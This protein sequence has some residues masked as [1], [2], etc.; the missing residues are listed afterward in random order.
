MVVLVIALALFF[1]FTN[2]FHDT[3]N[4]MATPI[5]TGAIKP[6]TA[7]ALA[8]ILNLVGAF[9]STEVAKTISGGIIN[10]GGPNGVAITPEMIFA[11]LMGAVL[12]NLLTWLLG[13]PSSSS[14]ALFGG[15]IGAAIVGTW[16]L[17]AVN[18]M[19]VV[20]KV[21]LPA[22]LAP[23]IAG[24]VA[25]LCTK[26]AYGITRRSDPDSGDKLTQ[27]R[28]GF[29]RGQVFSSSLVA[30][31]HGTNDAQKTMGVI[32]LVL[33]ASGLQTAGTGPHIWV[34][35][36]CALAIAGGTYAG[37]WRIIRTLGSGLTDV[38]PAQGFAA[39]TSTAAAILAS[40]HLGFALSTT[41]VASG[42]VIGSGLGRK[43]STVRW[44]AIGKIGV[45]WLLT[46][47]SAAIVGGLA[48]LLIRTGT[49]GIVIVA[50]LGLGAILYMFYMSQREVVDHNNA[51]SDVD[52]VGEA[53][54]IPS[55]KEREKLAAKARA[56]QKVADK[57]AKRAAE[58]DAVRAAA[59]NALDRA[60][61]AVLKA[62]TKAA[63]E[64][65]APK[66]KPKAKAKAKP[67]AK[68]RSEPGP[69]PEAKPVT[70]VKL[71]AVEEPSQAAGEQKGAE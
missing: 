25:Y 12:W 32:T 71:P 1:D 51:I 11:G 31:A 22:V 64:A 4:A 10:E 26:L 55:K 68:P 52:A 13:L 7:V 9:L 6:K 66:P 24:L 15:L 2:G 47:P 27:K 58:T 70:K 48:A 60:D 17:G 23:T 18:F 49:V 41:H 29:R 30:L 62:M 46:L 45:A 44:G 50:V 14:H 42:S 28:G 59:Q 33:V 61:T 37:G 69:E 53:M 36:A 40:S 43:G 20:S 67:K 21:L 39:E 35:T 63:S 56:A 5:A 65:N 19:V 38:K 8:A 54:H 3:A 57:A 16:S 34:I